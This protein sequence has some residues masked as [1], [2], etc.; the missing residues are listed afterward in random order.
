MKTKQLLLLL[1]ITLSINSFSQSNFPLYSDTFF[2]YIAAHKLIKNNDGSMLVLG[3]VNETTIGN[4]LPGRGFIIG[5]YDAQ[6]NKLW[7][8]QYD[9]NIPGANWMYASDA[10]KDYNG[11]YVVIID[12]GI[13]GGMVIEPNYLVLTKFDENGN[14]LWTNYRNDS[15]ANGF[16][17]NHKIAK[18]NLFYNY[19][20]SDFDKFYKFDTLGNFIYA[21]TNYGAFNN[22]GMDA[23][24]GPVYPNPINQ[25]AKMYFTDSNFNVMS[26]VNMSFP[27]RFYDVYQGSD[28]CWI[29]CANKMHSNC[30]A[31]IQLQKLRKDGSL[32]WNKE[33]DYNAIAEG[34]HVIEYNSNYYITASHKTCLNSD[35]TNHCYGQTDI[36]ILQTDT[37]GNL[38]G[39]LSFVG[40]ATK[41][42]SVK[43][44]FGYQSI[45]YNDSIV[46]LGTAQ[47]INENGLNY[48][49]QKTSQWVI[50]K[51]SLQ[52][53]I[54]LTVQNLNLQNS[55]KVFPNPTSGTITLHWQQATNQTALVQLYT[56]NGVC[57]WQQQYMA[58]IQSTFTLPPIAAGNYIMHVYNNST[59]FRQ[60]ISVVK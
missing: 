40:N 49:S 38:I 9:A 26:S 5:K 1:F 54:P 53:F 55:L 56:L 12:S 48:E 17:F 32:L 60:L 52:Q 36:V 18:G 13:S 41:T 34:M 50:I 8:K 10:V 21:N 33:Y 31:T 6:G 39:Q 15:N 16:G 37:A 51:N 43:S 25:Y 58:S 4:M 46:T 19:I 3:T 47:I 29:M 57:V 44:Y 28:S 45:I 7:I 2:H 59:N 14:R 35:T 42:D 30:R 20:V 24:D 22:F 23:A 11:G 27:G